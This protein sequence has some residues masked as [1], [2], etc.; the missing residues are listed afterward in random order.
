[1][2]RIMWMRL[3]IPLVLNCAASL[4]WAAPVAV[5]QQLESITSGALKI[6]KNNEGAIT[7][8][9]FLRGLQA[10]DPKSQSAVPFNVGPSMARYWLGFS[11]QNNGDQARMMQ[12]VTG[13]AYRPQLTVEV[14]LED[15]TR[16]RVL[17][18]D[19]STPFS[20]RDTQSRHLTSVPFQLPPHERAWLV[21]D[22][23]I[24]GSSYLPLRLA[25]PAT[26][27]QE[28][29]QDERIAAWFYSFSLAALLLF[30][31]FGLAMMDGIVVRYAGLFL[32]G[33]LCIATMEG[34]AFRSLWPG[35]PGWNH[36]SPLVLLYLLV[37][38][39]C[40]VARHSITGQRLAIW[41]A[42]ALTG[43]S[44]V[45]LVAI[46]LVFF[47][48]FVLMSQLLNPLLMIMF[49]A[50]VIAMSGWLDVNAKPNRIAFFSA[51]IVAVVV[52]ALLLLAQDHSL[53]PEQVYIQSTRLIFLFIMLA[54]IALLS[55]HVRALHRNHEAALREALAAAE[56]EAQINRSLF[57]AEQNYARAQKLATQRRE[58]LASASHDM[59]QPLVSLR[60]TIDALM[61]DQADSTR[62]QLSNAIDYLESLC[63]LHLHDTSSAQPAGPTENPATEARLPG[64]GD[65]APKETYAA[66]L[67]METALRMFQDEAADKGIDLRARYCTATLSISPMP[68]MRIYSNLVSNALKHSSAQ[69]ILL[70]AR[71]RQGAVVLKVMDNGRGMSPE[72]LETASLPNK[73]GPESS[74]HGLGL[75]ICK[76]LAREHGLEF[77]IWSRQ[78]VGTACC[79]TIPLET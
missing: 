65:N 34:F 35:L 22:Y 33:L 78:G 77:D 12:L 37:A 1:M 67:I 62:A 21:I 20:E 64:A 47:V 75:A 72:L 79:L 17:H 66:G 29:V 52:T 24:I 50:H 41:L 56:R 76:Q 27:L 59:K 32:L 70:G 63:N 54:T 53:L 58:Q 4:G 8:E 14:I 57:E 16:L 7:R 38:V 36:F 73:K 45:S 30:G 28:Q 2:L 60:A 10:N 69:R 13:A 71:R 6:L 44:L 26:V 68:I 5:D 46:P 49:L 11:I 25:T 31:L 39:G 23:Q 55:S 15:M 19:H 40:W 3:I 74:G 51:I 42:P 9:A 43:V 18:E 48:D 61:H